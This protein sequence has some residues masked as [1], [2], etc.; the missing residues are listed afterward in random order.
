MIT[1]QLVFYTVGQDGELHKATLLPNTYGVCVEALGAQEISIERTC[2]NGH[3]VDR[4]FNI[5][6]NLC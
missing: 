4:Q 1:C 3:L 2:E 6:V 5:Y